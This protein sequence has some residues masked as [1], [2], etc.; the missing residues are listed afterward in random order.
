LLFSFGIQVCLKN[1]GYAWL[2]F[3]GGLQDN[4][5]AERFF[6]NLKME[7]VWQREYANHAEAKNDITDYIVRFYNCER[8]HSVLGNLPLCLNRKWQK[9]DLL[10]CPKLLDHYSQLPT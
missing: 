8:M 3:T 5:V 10:K 9:K 7:R 1:S 2:D 4:A 6:L